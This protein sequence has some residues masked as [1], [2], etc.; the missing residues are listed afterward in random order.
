ML[1]FSDKGKPVALKLADAR[2]LV[3]TA[4]ARETAA[5]VAI[6]PPMKRFTHE[7]SGHLY[8]LV[9]VANAD[10]HIHVVALYQVPRAGNLPSIQAINDVKKD[11][12][13][14][15]QAFMC[16]IAAGMPHS[17]NGEAHVRLGDIIIGYDGVLYFGSAKKYGKELILRSTTFS[18]PT[19]TGLK[20]AAKRLRAKAE[21][22]QRIWE[23]HLDQ[24]VA[25]DAKWSRP[26]DATDVWRDAV[27]TLPI[28]KQPILW[29]E[30]KHPRDRRRL[31]RPGR[32]IVFHGLI[33]S[34]DWVVADHKFR[35]KLRD[36]QKITAIEMEGAG[37]AL[38]AIHT[39]MEY[40]VVRGACDYASESK[41]DDWQDH[42][43]AQ[44]AAMTLALIIELP[45]IKEKWQR[46]LM[47]IP[48]ERVL[49]ELGV[50]GEARMPVQEP[51]RPDAQ[52]N[53][54]PAPGNGILPTSTAASSSPAAVVSALGV[55][56]DNLIVDEIKRGLQLLDQL[57][58]SYQYNEAFRLATKIKGQLDI[59][60]ASIPKDLRADALY[61]LALVAVAEAEMAKL[62][63]RAEKLDLTEARRLLALVQE[64]DDES[65]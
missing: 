36:H 39:E 48:K 5:V 64:I 1:I 49:D 16:G 61:R 30:R 25:R 51:P 31:S 6:F 47:G 14:I 8:E 24:A 22:G 56:A 60:K 28:V 43:A 44:A 52:V 23:D 29:R 42:A 12:P 59:Y 33:G 45:V 4:L 38:G 2:I 63:G 32:P 9:E 55:H 21:S 11:L 15:E 41:N 27:V 65:H 20:S 53:A 18:L 26:L 13:S 10:G 57:Q 35:N 3:L 37:V 50:G 40:L 19:E 58:D 34:S 46:N 62:E 7:K 54:A 17:S